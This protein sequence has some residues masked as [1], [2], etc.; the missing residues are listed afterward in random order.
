MWRENGNIVTYAY[1]PDKPSSIRCGED[2]KWSKKL[3]S[4]KWHDIKMW[5]KLND[6]GSGNGEFKAWL[7]G[8]EV[9]PPPL[10]CRVGLVFLACLCVCVCVC[11][12]NAKSRSPRGCRCASYTART[13]SPHTHSHFI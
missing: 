4:G 11:A 3:D 7:D 13:C 10:H 6:V 5:I 12:A 9:R 2:W 1:Y 8:D